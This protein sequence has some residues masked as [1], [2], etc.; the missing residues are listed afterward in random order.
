MKGA[1]AMKIASYIAVYFLFWTMS[2]FFILP[3]GVKTADELGVEKIKGQAESA[4]AN[5]NPKRIIIRTTIMATALFVLFTL[6]SI[7]GWLTLDNFNVFRL[8]DKH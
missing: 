4:P 6:N 3:F 7:Y 1:Y 5:Y 2:A 8:S